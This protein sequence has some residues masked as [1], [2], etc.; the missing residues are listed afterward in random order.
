[1]ATS[2]DEIEALLRMNIY[3][4]KK[5]VVADAVRARLRSKPGLKIE[6]AIRSV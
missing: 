1:M 5:D 4:S 6:V 2:E 3:S